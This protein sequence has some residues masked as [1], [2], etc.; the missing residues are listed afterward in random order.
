MS[1]IKNLIIIWSGPAGHTAAIYAARA[2][3]EPLMFEGFLAGGIA[4]WG[5]LTTTTEVEN[6][7]WFPKGI[8][9]PELMNNMRE[10]SLH[11][12]C[13]IKTQTVDRVDLSVRPYKVFVG[14][15]SYETKAL[16]ISTW[17]IAKRLYLTGEE[18]Y[19][20]KG[21]SACAVCDGGLPIFRNKP[22]VVIGGGDSACE[23]ANYLSKFGSKVYLLVRKDTLRASKVMQERT[24]NNSKI[25]IMRNTEGVEIV[26]NGSVMTGLHI[27]NNQTQQKILLEASGLFYA[28]GHKPNTDF[29]EGQLLLDEAW[30]ILVKPWTTQVCLPQIK[31][32]K[33]ETPLWG[34]A[35]VSQY[36]ILKGVFA[37]WDV[38][39][40]KYRQAITSAG[41]GCMAALEA[42]HF[43]QWKI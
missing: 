20:Q 5:Q 32:E 34:S 26:G 18:T 15:D 31:W 38:A 9:W 2:M 37:A 23:E 7:P 30:Y 19:R 17:A 11:A 42:E 12:G 10:Q 24:K 35:D 6:F 28:I 8:Q 1:T 41:T 27:I 4:A 3:L 14:N 22:L 21:V 29:L 33:L 43:L 40:K 39:D 16:I 36:T 13:M 25:E